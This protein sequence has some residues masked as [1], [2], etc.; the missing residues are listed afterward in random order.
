[1][2]NNEEKIQI[3]NRLVKE[4]AIDF[5]E[6]LKLLE[7]EKE[8]V[9]IPYQNPFPQPWAEPYIPM[10]PDPTYTTHDTNECILDMKTKITDQSFTYACN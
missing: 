6:A 10:W 3:I 5:I 7:T 4:G 8:T 1:M 9:Y 2:V